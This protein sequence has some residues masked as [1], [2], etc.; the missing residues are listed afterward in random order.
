VRLFMFD[1]RLTTFRARA[2]GLGLDLSEPLA[3]GRLS[4]VQIEPTQMSPGEFANEVV[5]AVEQDG[6]TLLAI[7][8]INGYMNAMP[9]ERLLGV[10]LHELLSY[11]ADRGV[12]SILT[13]VQH[14]IFGGPVD[15]AV[16]VSY[17]ADAVILL[18]YFEFQG[19][20][21]GAISV[22]KK[23]SGPHEHTIRECRVEQGGLQVGEPLT[24]FHGVLTGVPQYTGPGAPLMGGGSA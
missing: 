7:D 10:Q 9:T 4:I 1:E 23:R 17:L 12:T 19:A 21:R 5:R 16:E 20:V 8:S 22:V 13:L 24:A 15:E 3:D 2:D 14:G 11:L 6:V 18:R